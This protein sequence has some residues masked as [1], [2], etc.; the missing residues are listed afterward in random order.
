MQRIFCLTAAAFLVATPAAF[1]A[2]VGIGKKSG[3]PIEINSDSLEVLQNESRAIFS[4]HVVAVQGQMRLKSDKMIVHYRKAEEQKGGSAEGKSAI[5]KIEVQGNVFL[6]S[7]EETASGASG[8]YDVTREEVVLIN[9]VVVTRGQNVLKGDRL[10]YN[11]GT[12]KSVISSAGATQET[13]KKQ[14]VRALF[15]PGSEEKK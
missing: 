9:N 2:D 1:A 10:T 4:G 8:T 5:D 11:L 7:P 13:G 14:R 3:E 15:V 6:S 12:G